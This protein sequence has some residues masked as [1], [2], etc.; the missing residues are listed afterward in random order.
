MKSIMKRTSVASICT[1]ILIAAC[2]RKTPPPPAFSFEKQI[3]VAIIGDVQK[4]CL[5][6]Y[7][8]NIAVGAT[9]TL[10]AQPAL[11]AT[12]PPEIKQAK[13]TERLSERC[14]D[15]WDTG[16]RGGD[17]LTFYRFQSTGETGF[18]P[19]LAILDPIKPIAVRE[20]KIDA[21][22][23]G[24]G[25]K[26]SFRVCASHEG[27]HHQVWTGEPLTGKPRFHWYYYA[28]YDTEP[29]CTE[30]EYFGAK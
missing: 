20:G 30:R 23:D 8:P 5:M 21:D 18:S 15:H 25:T 3:G 27:V 17:G 19:V 26:E 10:V 11:G 9:L 12:E 7:N 4:S 24:D 14:D 1:L 2:A 29:S 28:G 16:D 22:L 13:V 6:M